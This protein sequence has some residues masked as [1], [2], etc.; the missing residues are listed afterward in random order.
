MPLCPET[1]V[2]CFLDEQAGIEMQLENRE[3]SF[4]I[5]VRETQQEQRQIGQV[6]YGNKQRVTYVFTKATAEVNRIKFSIGQSPSIGKSPPVY[7]KLLTQNELNQIDAPRK[8]GLSVLVLAEFLK[9][10]NGGWIDFLETEM[11]VIRDHLIEFA[12]L[13]CRTALEKILDQKTYW[14]ST[15]LTNGAQSYLAQTYKRYEREILQNC[16]SLN[17]YALHLT[18]TTN[19]EPRDRVF[20]LLKQ[21]FED[22]FKRG[23]KDAKKNNLQVLDPTIVWYN[24]LENENAETLAKIMIFCKETALREIMKDT[25]ERDVGGIQGESLSKGL[26]KFLGN[27][28]M[29]GDDL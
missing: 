29:S 17:A 11:H 2:V 24:G 14:C 28:I 6:L 21:N 23:R 26:T 8:D 1:I 13:D 15:Y 9:S 22:Q 7:F 3:L 16:P 10:L 20:L 12:Y 25:Y 18:A 4:T 5:P 27:S 19:P